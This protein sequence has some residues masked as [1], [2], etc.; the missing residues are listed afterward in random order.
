MHRLWG[1]WGL[2]GRGALSVVVK[3]LEDDR[4]LQAASAMYEEN[5]KRREQAIQA[6]EKDKIERAQQVE[7]EG[8][9][10][11]KGSI[12]TAAKQSQVRHVCTFLFGTRVG[13]CVWFH[14][15]YP[16]VNGVASFWR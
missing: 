2:W 12:R 4:V 13:S 6:S 8:Q 1:L 11:Y 10:M 14:S 5:A 7:R 9:L 16:V 15:C 3:Q